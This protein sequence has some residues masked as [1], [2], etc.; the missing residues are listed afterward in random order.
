M[1]HV[2]EIDSLVFVGPDVNGAN[3]GRMPIVD[4][5]VLLYRRSEEAHEVGVLM[6]CHFLIA[7]YKNL[8]VYQRLP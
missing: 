8:A 6:G 2:P 5:H 7:D 1:I 3:L 4:L